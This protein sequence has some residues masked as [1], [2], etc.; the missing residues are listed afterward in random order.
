M[1]RGLL[2]A[3][4]CCALLTGGC[5]K[6]SSG[7]GPKRSDRAE[8]RI[9]EMKVVSAKAEP[10]ELEFSLRVELG[11]GDASPDRSVWVVLGGASVAGQIAK[12]SEGKPKS[13][14]VTGASGPGWA[15]ES[16]VMKAEGDIWTGKVTFKEMRVSGPV[17]LSIYMF[18]DTGVLS[19]RLDYV[20][21]FAAGQLREV[22][23]GKN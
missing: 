5:K 4:L 21:D 6:D 2:L 9:S 18:D 15:S 20:M 10:P 14:R 19:N 12:I 16:C 7:G 3:A 13:E 23:K 1:A 8:P 22:G 11:R 17:P